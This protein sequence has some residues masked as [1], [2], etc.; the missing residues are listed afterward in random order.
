MN[1][2]QRRLA[3]VA[4]GLPNIGATAFRNIAYASVGT[5]GERHWQAMVAAGWA[6]PMPSGNAQLPGYALTHAGA[7]LAIDAHETLPPDLHQQQEL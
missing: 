6:V 3:R 1:P 5:D 4:L 7:A 2:T